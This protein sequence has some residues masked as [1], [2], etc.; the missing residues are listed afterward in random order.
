MGEEVQRSWEKWSEGKLLPEY[1]M[2]ENKSI[3][4]KMKIKNMVSA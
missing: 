3:F 4:N 2:C 1:T